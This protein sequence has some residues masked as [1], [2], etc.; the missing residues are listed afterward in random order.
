VHRL[1]SPLCICWSQQ[2]Q[3]ILFVVPLLFDLQERL[4]NLGSWRAQANKGQ[5]IMTIPASVRTSHTASTSAQLQTA[6]AT[7]RE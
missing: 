1:R 3:S 4:R 2:R 5:S 7:P 6:L